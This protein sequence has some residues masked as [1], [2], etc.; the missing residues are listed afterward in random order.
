MRLLPPPFFGVTKVEEFIDSAAF[1]FDLEG[2]RV[3]NFILDLS[4][5][6]NICLA[7]QLL[8]YKFVS[9]S[10][11]KEC[12]NSPG[13]IWHPDG[14]LLSEFRSSGFESILNNH[15]SSAGKEKL[16]RSYKDLKVTS[17]NNYLIAPQRLLRREERERTFLEED[18]I[19]R[20][21]S[22]YQVPKARKLVT[23]T[24]CE[25][26]T[27]FWAHATEDSGTVIVARG[28]QSSCEIV[29]A[30]NGQG[31]VTTLRRAMPTWS[32]LRKEVLLEKAFEKGVTSKPGTFHMGYGLWIIKELIQKSGS[33]FKLLSEG[34]SMNISEGRA[35]ISQCGYW[36]G[37]I[38]IIQLSLAHACSLVDLPELRES[39]DI[40]VRWQ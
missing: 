32:N 39:D 40:N 1:M 30:D 29:C 36:K 17:N 33:R 13:L 11:E 16:F 15:I 35:R 19:S 26:L 31:V 6:R 10:S 21:N 4:K 27:N 34:V 2:R 14:K 20:I 38:A 24:L 3:P 18:F 7:G 37:T 28:N 12:F 9:Y 8:I 5:V 25:T 22:F 23:T